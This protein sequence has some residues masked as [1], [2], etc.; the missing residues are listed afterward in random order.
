MDG[1]GIVAMHNVL[2]IATDSQSIGYSDKDLETHFLAS[3]LWLGGG[4]Y[5]GIIKMD[6]TVAMNT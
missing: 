5:R 2:N 4:G 6:V 1:K 3:I